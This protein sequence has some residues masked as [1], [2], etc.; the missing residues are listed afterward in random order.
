MKIAIAIFI[1]VIFTIVIYA[2]CRIAK[3]ARIIE[4]ILDETHECDDYEQNV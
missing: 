4:G 2:F 3:Q 1:L